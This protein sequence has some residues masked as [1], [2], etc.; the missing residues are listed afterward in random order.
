MDGKGIRSGTHILA[1]HRYKK[2]PD[3]PVGNEQDFQQGDTLVYSM[4]H[5]ENELRWLEEDGKG[6]VGYVPVAYHIIII[7]KTL[8]EEENQEIRTLKEE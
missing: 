8:Q 4:E 6:Q 3:S 2:N 5:D 7:D 1:T